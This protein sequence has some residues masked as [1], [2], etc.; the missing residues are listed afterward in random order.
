M[1]SISA[2][3]ATTRPAMSRASSARASTADSGSVFYF[4]ASLLEG[5][6]VNGFGAALI[7]SLIYSVCGVVIDAAI[8]RLFEPA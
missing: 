7:G 6:H 5:L 2:R 8:E 3:V 4:A 1:A